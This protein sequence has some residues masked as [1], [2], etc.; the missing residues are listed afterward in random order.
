[1]VK[2]TFSEFSKLN[3]F[4]PILIFNN[5][6]F[7]KI[8]YSAVSDIIQNSGISQNQPNYLIFAFYNF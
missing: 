4:R 5:V 3:K 2:I 6:S 1:M 8:F 7:R